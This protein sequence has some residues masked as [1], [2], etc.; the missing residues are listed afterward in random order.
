MLTVPVVYRAFVAWNSDV[1]DFNGLHP[2]T[3]RAWTG[4]M[5]KDERGE[6]IVDGSPEDHGVSY[7][8]NQGIRLLGINE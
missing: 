1:L 7:S 8:R 3:G 2:E 6:W 5:K 4:T